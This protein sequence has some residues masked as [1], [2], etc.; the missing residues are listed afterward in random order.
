MRYVYGFNDGD[1]YGVV[2]LKQQKKSYYQKNNSSW[3]SYHISKYI[4]KHEHTY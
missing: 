2:I 4:N 1:V 3:P